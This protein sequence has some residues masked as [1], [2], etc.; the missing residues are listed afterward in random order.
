[1]FGQ[2]PGANGAT[3]YRGVD[4]KQHPLTH[5]PITLHEDVAH[6]VASLWLAYDGGKLDR[7]IDEGGSIQ[8]GQDVADSQFYQSDI[9][10]Y[11]A[12][13][14]AFTL[15]DDFFSNVM[16][17]SFPNHL[18]T[19][20]GHD[21]NIDGS[22]RGT[23]NAW[24]CDSPPGTYA[25]R[26]TPNGRITYPFP[27]FNFSTLGDELDKHHIPWTYYAPPQGQPGYF[28][29]SYDAIRHIRYGI[30]WKTRMR[31]SSQFASDAAAG[32][33]P[34]VSWLVQPFDVSDHPG[35]SICQGENWTVSQLNA[36]MSNQQEW[37][38]TAI[39]LTWDDYGGFYDHV[40]PPKGP[41]PLTEYGLRVPAIII[42]PYARAHYVDHTFLSFSSMLAF[43]EKLHRLPATGP[44]DRRAND[45]F[46]SFD[47][48]QK[49]LAPLVLRQQTCPAL[50]QPH[51]RPMKMYAI[52]GAGVGTLGTIWAILT[53]IPIA[54]ARPGT[55]TWLR[56][57][58]P[59][60]QLILGVV[61]LAA[62]AAFAIF[63]ATTYNLPHS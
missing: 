58:T 59:R 26:E 25:Q 10:D 1:M 32:H 45:L 46:S 13:A 49:P 29:N 48:E 28:W 17:N 42:S 50:P 41:N 31:N 27:C 60:L 34:E 3:T 57:R 56:R 39:I 11:W 6:D 14:K 12:Y 36:I 20:A 33:L 7:F 51:Y 44:L 23:L 62:F 15:D 55:I 21:N 38:H 18:F 52:T 53:A 4:G 47:F 35:F 16:G 9:P 63:V 30:D 2:F 19:I 22:P 40:V 24:G 43:V 5:Q 54:A 61:F 8:D 37:E